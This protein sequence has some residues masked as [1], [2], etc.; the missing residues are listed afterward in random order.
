MD[1]LGGDFKLGG[2][3]WNHLMGYQAHSKSALYF[4][5]WILLLY[6]VQ[7]YSYSSAL[8]ENDLL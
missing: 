4:N 2:G 1:R 8:F 3:D 6:C 7:S 5:S